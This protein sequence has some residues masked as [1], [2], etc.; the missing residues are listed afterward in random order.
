[1]ARVRKP[2]KPVERPTTPLALLMEKH[3]ENLLSKNYSEY[4]IKG[5]RVHI[6]F[7]L[8]WVADRGMCH[9]REPEAFAEK[10]AAACLP[11]CNAGGCVP[12]A[13]GDFC[14]DACFTMQSKTARLDDSSR[15]RLSGA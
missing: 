1:M 8:A 12:G 7:F 4:T 14:G 3:L 10:G 11:R 2:R 9:P 13:R 6:G 15:L 5:R